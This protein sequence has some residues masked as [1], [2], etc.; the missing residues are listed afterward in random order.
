MRRFDLA[1]KAG[2]LPKEQRTIKVKQGDSIEL[3]WNSDQPLRLHLHGYDIELAVKPGEPAVMSFK[4]NVAGR[5][6]VEKL[7][8]EGKGGHQHGGKVLYLEVHPK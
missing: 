2:D 8:D 1:L 6:S 5:F 3:R 7:K 4:G